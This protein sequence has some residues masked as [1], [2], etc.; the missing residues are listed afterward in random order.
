M[1]FEI[2]WVLFLFVI[3]TLLNI[4]EE[5]SQ[6][7]TSSS[8]TIVFQEYSLGYGDTSEIYQ[9]FNHISPNFNTIYDTEECPYVEKVLQASQQIVEAAQSIPGLPS[10]VKVRCLELILHRSLPDYLP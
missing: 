4:S 8:E 7:N 5:T 1:E 2:R 3:I 10:G 6:D 9:S